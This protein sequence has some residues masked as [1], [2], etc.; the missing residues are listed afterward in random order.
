MG[1]VYPGKNVSIKSD[2]FRTLQ[3]LILFNPL[4]ISDE[5]PGEAER[6]TQCSSPFR[7]PVL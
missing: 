6:Q 1:P 3:F 2:I 5:D 4:P 7:E